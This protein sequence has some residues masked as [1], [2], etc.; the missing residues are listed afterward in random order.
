REL[1]LDQPATGHVTVG[2]HDIDQAHH[3]ISETLVKE[4]AVLD[5][6]FIP[7][8]PVFIRQEDVIANVW[9]QQELICITPAGYI[10][11]LRVIVR[12]IPV[13]LELYTVSHSWLPALRAPDYSR[14][15]QSFLFARLT[16][17]KLNYLSNGPGRRRSTG[18]QPYE[19]R[20]MA[21]VS[22]SPR[23]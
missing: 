14:A 1:F 13:L 9:D 11:R 21:S 5:H 8:L 17:A 7:L 12:S 19:H 20:V 6:T 22:R 15:S 10:K 4:A 23:R 18:P 3:I 16:R 2:E